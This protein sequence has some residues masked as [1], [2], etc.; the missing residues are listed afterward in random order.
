[1]ISVSE[2]RTKLFNVWQDIPEQGRKLEV[3]HRR[4]IYQVTIKPTDKNVQ[5]YKKRYQKSHLR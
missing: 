1:M 2:L 5:G 3:Y 4:K